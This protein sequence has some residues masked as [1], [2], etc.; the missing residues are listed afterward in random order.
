MLDAST[1]NLAALETSVADQTA[2]Y[3]Q[4]VHDAIAKTEEAGKLVTDH[5]GALQASISGMVTEFSSILGNVDAE[6]QSINTAAENLNAVGASTLATLDERR[7]AMDALAESFAARADDIDSRMRTFAQSIADTVNDTEHRLLTARKTM[8]EMLEATTTTVADTLEQSTG[9]IT[10]SLTATTDQIHQ[11]LA[12]TTNEVQEAL[13]G[14]TGNLEAALTSTTEQLQHVLASTAD[15]VHAALSSSTSE[16]ETSLRNTTNLLETALTGTS[17]KVTSQL[18][19]FTSAANTQSEQA[20]DLLRQTQATMILEMQQALEEAT[21][22]FTETATAMRATA[23]EVGTE[24]ENTRSEL[25]RGV[26]E[27]PEETRASAAAM[28]RVVAEQIEALSELNAIVRAQ[29][30]THD[31][32]DRRS[33]PPP[34]R[35]EEPVRRDPPREPATVARAVPEMPKVETRAEPKPAA[36]PTPPRA[37]AKPAAPKPA[38]APARPAPAPK[39]AAPA[40]A[41]K[42]AAPAETKAGEEGGGW[43]RDVLRNASAQQPGAAPAPES[44]PAEAPAQPAQKNLT[45]LTDEIARSMDTNALSEAWRRYQAGEQAVFSRRI[46][47]LS[48]QGTYDEVRK[49]IQ[50]DADFAKTAKT[51]MSEFEQLLQ[52]A[53]L[54]ANPAQEALDYLLSDRGKVYTMLAHASGRLG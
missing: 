48:G 33:N 35:R 16:M 46:Y 24:L 44:A 9:S 47:T 5:V 40:A 8:E 19:E 20:A 1:A 22:R 53:A 6:A 54:G 10:G 50:R 36:A 39:P 3:S 42:P 15:Q 27:L 49:R 29:P 45:N 21:Q 18:G 13:S 38:P 7:T 23:K 52:Q 28:R 41:A 30:A 32:N 14:A 34:P 31:L 37:E 25:S 2:S 17:E 43:L 4:T 12:S 11:V 26:M 51:Y